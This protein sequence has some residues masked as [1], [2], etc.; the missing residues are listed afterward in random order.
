LPIEKDVPRDNPRSEA[1]RIND[2]GV[3][4]VELVDDEPSKKAG[5]IIVE[6]EDLLR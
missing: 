4:E 3:V 1:V 2:D 5:E 6:V